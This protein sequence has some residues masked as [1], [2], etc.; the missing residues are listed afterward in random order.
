MT[1]IDSGGSTITIQWSGRTSTNTQRVGYN[2][3]VTAQPLPCDCDRHGDVAGEDAE[4]NA[5]DVVAVVDH[6]FRGGVPPKRDLVC[7]HLNRGDLNC[8]AVND[9][10]D[11]VRLIDIAFRGGAD[12]CQPCVCAPYPAVCQ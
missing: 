6:V 8:D 1:V 5:L 3:T 7:P 9:I 12:P 10:L 11:V 2:F 4:M